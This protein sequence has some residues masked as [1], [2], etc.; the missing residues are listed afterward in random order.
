MAEL[1]TA[2]DCYSFGKGGYR[3]V[4]SSSLTGAVAFS[5]APGSIRVGAHMSQNVKLKTISS[6]I[7]PVWGAISEE[8]L[9]TRPQGVNMTN[10]AI[11]LLIGKQEP[12]WSQRRVFAYLGKLSSSRIPLLP[13]M[14][15]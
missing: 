1:V 15:V 10:Q 6:R 3:K 8:R 14:V 11:R 2:S 7:F 5:C 13:L 9:M 12:L 4:V